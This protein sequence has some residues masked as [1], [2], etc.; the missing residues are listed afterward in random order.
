M[1]L[2]W[3]DTARAQHRCVREGAGWFPWTHQLLEITGEEALDF[4]NG[5]FSANFSKT[6]V[7]QSKY[8]LMLTEEGRIADDTIVMHLEEGCWLVTTMDAP[9]MKAAMER[10][11]PRYRVQ[12]RE[13][14]GEAEMFAVQGPRAEE[15]LAPLLDQPSEDIRRFRF[16]RR[17]LKGIPVL[18]HRSGFTGENGFEIFCAAGEAPAVQALL[19]SMPGLTSITLSEVYLR[20]LS[21]EKG[22]TLQE[23][24]QGLYPEEC[25]LGRSVDLAK[26]FVGREALLQRPETPGQKLMGLEHDGSAAAGQTLYYAG[27]ACGRVTAATYGFTAE[28]YIGY[29]VVDAALAQSGQRMTLPDGSEAVLTEKGWL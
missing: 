1:E 22:L 3:N 15:L 7:G 14:T 28:K 25:G 12:L 11:L 24:I 2:R 9:A 18:L 29:A 13:R 20:S 19:E 5:F 8:T 23:D 16:A 6:A 10:Q 26:D 17:C 21:V 27:A 4:L